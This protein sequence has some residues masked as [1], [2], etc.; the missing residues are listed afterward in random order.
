MEQERKVTLANRLMYGSGDMFGGGSFLL[1]GMLYMFFLTEVVGLSPALA[2]MVFMVGKV[3]DAISD[4]L[5]GYIS[6][7]TNSN[8]GRRRIY[9]LLGLLPIPISFF[10]LWLPVNFSTNL[11]LFLYYSF[12]YLLFNTV[13]TMVMVPYSAL[14]AEITYDYQERTRLSGFRI[15]F[16]QI[17]ALLAGTI[18]KLIINSYPNNPEKGH[19]IMAAVFSVLYTLPWLFVYFGTWELPYEKST[20]V[21]HSLKELFRSFGAIFKNVSFRI[22]MGMYICAYSAMDILMALFAYYLRYSLDQEQAYPLAMGALLIT[23]IFACLVYIKIANTQ[24]KGTAF[25]TGLSLWAAAMIVS[26]TLGPDSPVALLV[27]VSIL[28]GAG[29]SAGVMIPWAILPSITDVDEL[30]TSKKR[31]GIYAGAMTLTRKMIQGVIAMPV[32]GFMLGA[33]GYVPNQIQ[34]PETLLK[35]KLFFMLGPICLIVLGISFGLKFKITPTTHAILVKEITR[36]K[37]GGSKDDVQP[38]VKVVC[39]QLSGY[40]YDD[41]YHT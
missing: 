22:H 35:L 19:L 31:A 32:V 3:W 15:I 40:R 33:I 29:L 39:E 30:I 14:N 37:E 9:F 4:P 18:P 7:H 21:E 34:T 17:S 24:G 16:S 20:E 27:V 25:V 23:Q 11:S 26:Y 6:D 10:L 2:G 8:V 28:I 36:L 5:M 41:V 1:I 13:F 38:D 12:A